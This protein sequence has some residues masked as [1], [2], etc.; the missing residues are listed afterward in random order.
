MKQEVQT[1]RL[2]MSYVESGP[3]DGVPVV[4][5]SVEVPAAV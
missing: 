1:D 5:L 3:A 4:M 2:R